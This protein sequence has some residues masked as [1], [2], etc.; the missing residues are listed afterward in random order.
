MFWRG[1]RTA[2]CILLLLFLLAGCAPEDPAPHQETE[3]D[4]GVVRLVYVEWD[5]EIASTHV[6]KAVIEDRLGLECQLLPVTLTALWASVAAGDQDATVAAWLPLQA[7]QQARYGDRVVDLG[8][9]LEGTRIGLAVPAHLPVESIPELAGVAGRLDGKIIGI[10]PDAGIM[11]RT[12]RALEAYAL[13]GLRLISGSDSTMTTI[14]EGAV[15]EDRWIVVTAWTPHWMFQRWDLRYLQDPR[16]VYGE[17]GAIHTLVRRGLEEDRPRVYDFLSRF[18]WTV[19]DMEQVMLWMQEEG[20]S[21]EEAARRWIA[22]NEALVD[23][24]L[25]E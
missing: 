24:W 15:A 3:A 25:D 14:L 20:T 4:E 1:R 18:R 10:E 22:A 9:H 2:G 17:G 7:D 19:R 6:V 23:R 16:G 12:R 11:R 21:P 8:P 5:S 13:D